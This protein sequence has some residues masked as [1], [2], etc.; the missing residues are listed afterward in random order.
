MATGAAS[1]SWNLFR[2]HAL[3]RPIPSQPIRK[4]SRLLFLEELESRLAPTANVLVSVGYYDSVHANPV[5]PAPWKGSSNV[6]FW[7]GTSDG[8]YDAG[9]VLLQNIGSTSTT[10]T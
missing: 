6:S 5:K 10:L 9:A 3:N 2:L 7:G 1:M 8:F 4:R